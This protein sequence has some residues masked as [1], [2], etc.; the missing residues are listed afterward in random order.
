MG[1]PI[2]Q[3]D[4]A[5]LQVEC[6]LRY[7]DTV[8]ELVDLIQSPPPHRHSEKIDTWLHNSLCQWE[9]CWDNRKSAGIAKAV[10]HKLEYSI[11]KVMSTI[12]SEW[13]TKSK[14]AYNEFGR[15]GHAYEVK[16]TPIPNDLDLSSEEYSEIEDEDESSEKAEE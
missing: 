10:F 8:L 6:E 4:P 9:I 12:N 14:S 11:I 3:Q 15:R 7:R 16:I 2:I 13:I 5:V 1:E